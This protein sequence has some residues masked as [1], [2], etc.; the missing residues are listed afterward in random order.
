MARSAP[1]PPVT[2]V[3]SVAVLLA[4]L[5]S[6]PP[7]TVAVLVTLAGALAATFTASVMGGYEAP[8]A[9]ASARVQVE[10]GPAAQV[11]PAPLMAAAA[12]PAGSVSV[13]VTAPALGAVPALR[14]VMV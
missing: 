3:G 13:T 6:P 14:T 9:S 10:V 1:V 2:M 8:E 12:R 11:Q 4:A 7:D 5:M